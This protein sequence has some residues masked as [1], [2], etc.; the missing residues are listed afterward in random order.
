MGKDGGTLVSGR[1]QTAGPRGRS[2]FAS[3][4]V[5]FSSVKTTR[6]E[7]FSCAKKFR[8]DHAATTGRFQRSRTQDLNQKWCAAAA[9]GLFGS[10]GPGKGGDDPLA[11]R[12]L[13]LSLQRNPAPSRAGEHKAASRHRGLLALQ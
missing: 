2:R 1:R 7:S 5:P 3:V 6:R 9:A 10:R 13:I 11:K 12:N 4:A 8:A